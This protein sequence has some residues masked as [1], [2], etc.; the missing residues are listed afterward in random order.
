MS[1]VCQC[2][3]EKKRNT[4]LR[5]KEASWNIAPLL[6]YFRNAEF[7]PHSGISFGRPDLALGDSIWH[8]PHMWESPNPGTMPGGGGGG[9]GSPLAGFSPNTEL[10]FWL[11]LRS[12]LTSGPFSCWYFL[13]LKQSFFRYYSSRQVMAILCCVAQKAASPAQ[14]LSINMRTF[15][16]CCLG[17]FREDGSMNTGSVH[18]PVCARQCDG[19]TEYSTQ[20]SRRTRE[21]AWVY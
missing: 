8:F 11:F 2:N 17:R 10:V 21:N 12:Y 18:W 13:L 7:S 16:N 4:H 20:Y 6:S 14:L 5:V 1:T 19:P 9:L 15:W 3:K